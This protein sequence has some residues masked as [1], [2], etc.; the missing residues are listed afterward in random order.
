MTSSRQL[1][2]TLFEDAVD[3]PLWLEDDRSTPYAERV[4]RD[5]ALARA[6]DAADPVHR[7]RAWWRQ[8]PTDDRPDTGRRLDAARML[9]TL[10]M[11]ALGAVGGVG[12]ALAAFRYDGTY[13]VNVVRLLAL[14]VAP[15]LV[16]VALTLLMIPPRVPGLRVVQDALAALNPGA[17]AESLFR[18][19]APDA[20]LAAQVLGVGAGRVASGRFAKWQMLTWSQAAA[21]AFNV[22][23]LVTAFLL[24][25]FTDLAFG[26]STTLALDPPTVSRIVDA[27]A[28][29]WRDVVPAAVPGLELIERSQFFRLESLNG[30]AAGESRELAGWWSFT[31]LAIACYGLAPRIVLLAFSAWRLRAATRALLVDDPR[32]AALLDRM[33]TPAIE[34]AADEHETA[35]PEDGAAA[36]PAPRA[37]GGTARG[38]IWS[39]GIA[40]GVVRDYARRRL[41]LELT[42]VVE[43]GGSPELDAD[44]RAADEIASGAGPLVVFTPAWEPPLL[45]FL[46]FL[47]ALRE[48]AGP[49]ASIVVAP[50]AET[51]EPAA[52]VERDTWARAVGRLADPKVYVETGAA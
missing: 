46:D 24:I 6:L 30:F 33:A 32:V 13:P 12:V 22:A 19:F 51:V 2:T 49:D 3:V 4:Q 31:V 14:L 38:V 47:A 1:D 20:S 42:A 50:V 39:H 41:G 34:T 16:L 7:V 37:L 26:W 11:L 5:R 44:I 18:R 35:G 15:Q 21:V 40:P 8:L 52:D 23:A 25:T 17:L 28:W 48:R 9:A 10:A 45:E 27:I 29:P 36:A 43:A